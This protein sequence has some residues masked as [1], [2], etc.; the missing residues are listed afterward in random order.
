MPHGDP[1]PNGLCESDWQAL[2]ALRDR[3]LEEAAAA[4]GTTVDLVLDRFDRRKT[5][6]VVAARG[7]VIAGLRRQRISRGVPRRLLAE[8]GVPLTTT[9]IG[10]LLGICHSTVVKVLQRM[11]KAAVKNELYE[12]SQDDDSKA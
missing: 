2:V 6:A 4:H 7:A 8:G 11:Q 1:R 5:G 10:A 9:L 12:G 3:L